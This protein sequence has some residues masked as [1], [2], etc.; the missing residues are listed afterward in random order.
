[1]ITLKFIGNQYVLSLNSEEFIDLDTKEEALY[2][3]K[4]LESYYKSRYDK[5]RADAFMEAYRL[6]VASGQ[7]KAANIIVNYNNNNDDSNN[8]D[9][10]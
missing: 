4:I 10:S 6:L 2:V 1:M 3:K 9:G 5:G 8:M 7:E